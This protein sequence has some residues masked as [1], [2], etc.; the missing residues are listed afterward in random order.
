MS[1]RSQNRRGFQYRVSGSVARM[2]LWPQKSTEV[3][4]RRPDRGVE[5]SRG[6][7]RRDP[8]ARSIGTLTRKGR[9]SQGSQGRSDM[10]KARTIGSGQ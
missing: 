10:L 6:H 7:I 4:A 9:N 3:A 2:A 8:P 5:V 1:T